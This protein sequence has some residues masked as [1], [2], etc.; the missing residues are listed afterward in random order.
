MTGGWDLDQKGDVSY[1]LG[2]EPQWHKCGVVHAHLIIIWE[3]NGKQLIVL[4]RKLQWRKRGTLWTS[5]KA[6]EICCWPKQRCLERLI[7]HKIYCVYGTQ[8]TTNEIQGKKKVNIDRFR[9]NK[10]YKAMSEYIG[11]RNAL[12]CRSHHQKLEE[13]YLY[14]NKII[15]NFKQHHQLELYRTLK[16]DLE[17]KTKG[18]P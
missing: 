12:Q 11:T 15:A 16:A 3:L 4:P 5:Q 2:V 13:K 17:D 8:Q 1:F 9:T 18:R 14:P 10:F 6:T 7:T